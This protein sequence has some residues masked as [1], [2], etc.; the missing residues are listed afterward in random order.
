MVP[1]IA[2]VWGGAG[3]DA[4]WTDVPVTPLTTCRDLVDCCRDPGDEPCTLVQVSAGHERALSDS[5]R[6]LEVLQQWRGRGPVRLVLRYTVDHDLH[7]DNQRRLSPHTPLPSQEGVQPSRNGMKEPG[8]FA[9]TVSR[10]VSFPC[11]SSWRASRKSKPL[12]MCQSQRW[13]QQ[14]TRRLSDGQRKCRTVVDAG[15][16]ET[17]RQQY[18]APWRAAASPAWP[19]SC[20]SQSPAES[21][22]APRLHPPPHSDDTG[23]LAPFR[24]PA[25]RRT[26][27]VSPF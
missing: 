9:D 25:A 24:H 1:M 7:L 22:A 20:G 12:C 3:A 2:R 10:P 18:D 21:R 11:H 27:P 4:E 14:A 5:E 16:G 26:S 19:D 17:G 23:F 6:P 8:P 13:S 15:S